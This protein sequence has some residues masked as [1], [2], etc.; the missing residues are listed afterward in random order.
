[1]ASITI[2]AIAG[3]RSPTFALVGHFLTSR[4]KIPFAFN[5]GTAKIGEN[6]LDEDL[7]SFLRYPFLACCC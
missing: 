2:F 7:A 6:R 5:V 3:I 1:M 4:Q